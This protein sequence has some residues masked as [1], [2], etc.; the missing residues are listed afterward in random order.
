MKKT[1]LVLEMNQKYTSNS[2]RNILFLFFLIT[3]SC[4]LKQIKCY[5]YF[6]NKFQLLIFEKSILEIFLLF[7]INNQLFVLKTT[8]VRVFH[9][10]FSENSNT[11]DITKSINH[12]NLLWKFWKFIFLL[13]VIK[14]L[15]HFRIYR[16][17]IIK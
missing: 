2:F 12:G 9:H 1:M 6:Q 5:N 17:E 13:L 3:R 14:F 4:N 10:L 8:N 7:M 15:I 11:N 16:S